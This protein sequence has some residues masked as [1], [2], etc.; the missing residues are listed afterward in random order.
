MIGGTGWLTSQ[1]HLHVLMWLR[2]IRFTALALVLG[3]SSRAAVIFDGTFSGG[4]VTSNWT[5]GIGP[6]SNGSVYTGGAPASI[7]VIGSN[8][9]S[10]APLPFDRYGTGMTLFSIVMPSS[11][12]VRFAWD[13][14]TNDS[15]GPSADYGGYVLNSTYV[16]LSSA[17]GANMQSGV[18]ELEV[19]MGDYFA[20]YVDPTD[21]WGGAAFLTISTAPPKGIA[22]TVPEPSTYA[23]AGTA[24]LGLFC[25]RRRR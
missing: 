1:T 12:T 22:A 19:I 8:D 4:F 10:A 13:Y 21:N 2:T 6:N 3:L 15:F 5:V 9:D 24:L 11:G 7:E 25:L 23:L 14:R 17:S 20:F 16:D 18:A